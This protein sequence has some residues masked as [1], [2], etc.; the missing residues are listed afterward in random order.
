MVNSCQGKIAGALLK[1]NNSIHQ[2]ALALEVIQ[3]IYLYGIGK[4]VNS[5]YVCFLLSRSVAQMIDTQDI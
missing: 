5:L 3:V 1:N 4:G 2:H